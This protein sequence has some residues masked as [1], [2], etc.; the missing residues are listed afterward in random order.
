MSDTPPVTT[1]DDAALLK[2]ACE[3]N[4]Q[5]ELHY[6]TTGGEFVSAHTRVLGVD[7]DHL[8]LEEPQNI[9]KK[10]NFRRGQVV[11][12]Y[13]KL[14]DKLYRFQTRVLEFNR[15]IKLNRH[16]TVSGLVVSRPLELKEGQRRNHYRIGTV[17]VD[18]VL[19]VT[20]HGCS[21]GGTTGLQA[22]V[23]QGQLVDLSQGGARVLLDGRAYLRFRVGTLLFMGFRLPEHEQEFLFQAE[24]RYITEVLQGE[25]TR[26][27]LK[28]LPYPNQA[29]FRKMTQRLSRFIAQQQRV[30]LG[31][32]GG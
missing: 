29:G 10:V 25:A 28:F 23:W 6:E 31:H 8:F 9:G 22:E 11:D 30:E 12:A 4:R 32:A 5:L 2:D 20:L 21:P 19:P 14:H 18:Q 17:G 26:V 7:G 16:Q 13:L 1:L 15:P 24:T 3:R 27:G